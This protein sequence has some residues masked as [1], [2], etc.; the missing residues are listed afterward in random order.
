M[1]AESVRVGGRVIPLA[2]ATSWVS[3]YFD[4]D[5]NRTA[6]KPWGYPFYDHMVT[7]TGPDTL[8]DG[9]LL[10]SA[11]LNAA[12]TI[13]GFRTLQSMR[14]ILEAGLAAIPPDLTLEA[15][16]TNGSHA[17]RLAGLAEVLDRPDPDE[18]WA[19]VKGTILM[20][21]LHRKRP[22][23]VPLYDSKVYACY[24]GPAQAG[25]P[26]A[27]D[28][29]RTWACFFTRLAESMIR[30]LA[31]QPEAWSVLA[32]A[33]PA[34]VAPLRLLDVVAWSAGKGGG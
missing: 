9:D 5:A 8:G 3:S 4:A 14:P 12:P 27:R 7:G 2:H 25:Y 16:V 32:A 17:A 1:S 24:V 33:A 21:T 28:D 19:D 22:L 20:K 30:D 15:A 11:L 29:K 18:E 13:R 26:M 23:F 6:K 34:D 10:A 31:N